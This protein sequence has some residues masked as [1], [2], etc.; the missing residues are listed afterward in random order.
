VNETLR[1]AFISFLAQRI[2]SDDNQRKGWFMKVTR[3]E[4]LETSA[5]AVAAA[6]TVTT[7]K[8]EDSVK[9]GPV[10]SRFSP[11]PLAGNSEFEGLAGAGLSEEM[12]AVI[13]EAPRGEL[14]CWG[15]PFQVERPVL[16]RDRVVTERFQPTKAEWLVF[17]HTTDRE[18]LEK[19][20]DGLL[21]SKRGEGFL[22]QHVADYVFVYGDGTEVRE[23]IKRRHQ[24]G[25]F[26]RHWGENCFQAVGQTK[27]HP[28]QPVH[29]RVRLNERS[30]GWGQGETR[31]NPAD[32]A[33]WMNWLWAWKN[34]FPDKEIQEFRFEP[35]TG[36]VVI[37]GVTGGFV[38]SIPLRW[39]PRRKAVLQFAEG[40][41]FEP[42]LMEGGL[43]RQVQLDLGQVIS[44]EL[45]TVY[46]DGGWDDSYN[47]QLPDVSENRL[48]IEYTAHP[49]AEFHLEGG[50]TVP[51]ASLNGA[52]DGS[53]TP[54]SPATQQVT[55]RV[56]EMGSR[57]PV[58]V[59]LHVHGEAGEYL[60]PLDRHRQPNSSWFEDYCAEF[61]HQG[62]HRCV[63]ISGET[64]IKLPQGNVFL[65]ISK[66][67][68]IRPIRKTVEV[69]PETTEIE[70]VIERVL[71]W[72]ERGW[73]TADTHV[74]FLSPRTA[75]LEGAAEGVN[76]VNLLAS[77]WGELMTNV[78][79]FDGKTTF[80]SKEAGGDGEWLVRVGTENRQHVLGHISLLGYRGNAIVPICTGGIEESA[81]GDP[82]EVLLMEWAEQCRK[83]GGLVVL[84]HFPN[85]RC[86]NAAD[87]ISGVID[88]VEMTSWEN[89]Y[90]GIDPYS[91]ADYY[92]YLNC[93]HFLS[94][95]GGTDKMSAATA[96]GTVRTYARINS[97]EPFTYQSWLDAVKAGRTFVTYGPLLEFSVDGRP[98]GTQIE[99]AAGGGTL[100]IEWEA[101]SVT[102]PMSKIELVVN[103]EVKESRSVRP[104][105]DAGHWSLRVDQSCWIALLVR[106]HYADKPE[107]I[108]AHSSPV[109]VRVDKSSVFS[110]PDAMTTLDQI[111]GALAY[112]DTVGTRADDERYKQMRLRLTAAYR[113]LHNELHR[114]GHLHD[115]TAL[116]D[117]D[118]HHG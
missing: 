88:A 77:Q 100:D 68:E 96:V 26:T 7:A 93:G 102:V 25:M 22:A 44:A 57:V 23:S 29:E 105:S 35:K 62:F 28:L 118:E 9:D 76:I 79:D 90:M 112:L 107:I 16:L 15:I 98:A 13:P 74:H 108:A 27:P 82:I 69:R 101:S 18:E 71:P 54:V 39:E 52:G 30:G 97:D 72:R 45:Q 86:E 87:I 110:A 75:Q 40:T 70:L 85:P 109:M 46:P 37:S 36:T 51:V 106:G 65:E 14:A 1:P 99:L 59:K 60:A 117:H 12:A 103:G 41:K 19:N 8:A 56:V 49:D 92:R 95:V 53:L 115:H 66:G 89:L 94:A 20:E 11:I 6:R 64:V 21:V 116:T 55:I 63:Y 3:R 113:S 80:G 61:Q 114:R 4:F 17:L 83:Q 48:L 91:L 43:L 78:G 38:S 33:P 24:V 84:P 50:R 67:F 73:V 5:T 34:P 111:E 104:D 47:N 31:V 2:S 10:S 58:P 32:Q 42:R 81:L